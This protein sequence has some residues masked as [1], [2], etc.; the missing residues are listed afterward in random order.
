MSF[1]QRRYLLLTHVHDGG[2][3]FA[4]LWYSIMKCWFC[5][6]VFNSEFIVISYYCVARIGVEE[7]PPYPCFLDHTRLLY[8]EC[9]RATFSVALTKFLRM[10]TTYPNSVSETFP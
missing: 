8:I 7:F 2:P 1:L 9:F 6:P 5:I 4:D 10:E 3:R